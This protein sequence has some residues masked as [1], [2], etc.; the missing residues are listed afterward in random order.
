MSDSIKQYMERPKQY[1]NIDGTTEMTYGILFLGIALYGGLQALLPGSS[2]WR[3]TPYALILMEAVIIPFICLGYFA[4]K[5]IKRYI[6]YP[7]T[8]YVAYRTSKEFNWAKVAQVCA[9][10]AVIAAVIALLGRHIGAALL[11]PGLAVAFV[12]WYCLFGILISRTERWKWFVY[13]SLAITLLIILHAVNWDL[14]AWAP[15]AAL[16]A[17]LTYTASGLASLVLYMR[18]TK[19]PEPECE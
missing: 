3:H 6:T 17:A 14:L 15:R 8:G 12:A 1:A 19:A 9:A 7:R 10:I 18:R 5:A 13:S 11:L 2:I 4:P 16:L